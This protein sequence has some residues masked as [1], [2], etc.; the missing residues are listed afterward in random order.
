MYRSCRP[1]VQLQ[2][3]IHG[4]EVRDAEG[5]IGDLRAEV[6]DGREELGVP[7]GLALAAG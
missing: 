5:D 7:I 1:V 4:Y 2:W 6:G 3:T